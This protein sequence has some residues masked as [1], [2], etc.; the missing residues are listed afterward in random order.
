MRKVTCGVRLRL[1]AVVMVVSLPVVVLTAAF[2]LPWLGLALGLAAALAAVWVGADLL[3][4]RQVRLLLEAVQRLAAGDLRSR[5][6]IRATC[7]LGQLA[8]AI[9]RLAEAMEQQSSRRQKAEATLAARARQQTVVAALG[10]LALA[11]P[12]LQPLLDHVA[13]FIAQTLEVEFSQVWELT[14]DGGALQLRAGQGWRS[15]CVGRV[16]EPMAPDLQAGY[17]LER[18]E[19]VEVSDYRGERRFRLPDLFREHGVVSSVTVPVTLQDGR[20]GVLGAQSIRPRQF[21]EDEIHLLLS[22]SMLLTVVLERRKTESEM[23][24]LA[25][26]AQ[27]NPYPAFELSA[28]GAVTYCNAAAQRLAQAV[29]R[30]HPREL[31]PPDWQS[32]VQHCLGSGQSRLHYEVQ[33]AGRT[34]SW[35][36]HPVVP[37]RAVHCYVQDITDRLN[38]EAQLRQAQKME[39][40]GQLAAGVAHDFNNLLTIIQGHAGMLMSRSDLPPKLLE[41]SR[42]VYEAAERAATLTRQLLMF[43]RKNLMQARPLDLRDIVGNL[44]KMLQRLLGETIT[45]Q[46][47]SP[48]SLPLV[49]GDAGMLEQVL[50]NLAVNARDAMPKGGRL[51]IALAEADV[52]QAHVA[53]HPPGRV[54]RFVC[55]RVTD[56]GCGMDA[57]TLGRIFEP[58]FT[59]KEPGKGTGLGLATVYGIVQQHQGWIEVVSQVGVGTTFSIYLPPLAEAAVP[60]QKQPAEQAAAPVR[61][62][63]ERVLVVED[64]PVLLELA[65]TVLQEHGYQVASAS[66]GAEALSVWKARPGGFDLLLTDMVLPEGLSGLELAEQLRALKPDLKVLLTSGY[67]IDDI[68]QEAARRLG[69]R[70]LQKPYPHPALARAVR[71]CLDA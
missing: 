51:T 23:E 68:G 29:G 31:L 46:F 15:G 66:T 9:D 6:G 54:G 34:L 25:T 70:L 63:Q 47:Q 48:A 69:A 52:D 18:G 12:E 30:A 67:G 2:N 50:L 11:T 39:C 13:L 28:D 5:T 59:T 61:G 1:V 42:N 56:S 57:A 26:F 45:L 62:G 58:F 43:S 3:L 38:L 8:E 35:S 16:R 4:L 40:V 32:L 65:V 49:S 14:S 36:F 64:E 53:T 37:G 22:I 60:A 19:P 10:Q 55:L 27:L 24:K 17:T 33:T 71:E 21:T 7:E 44:S 20:Y 41:A